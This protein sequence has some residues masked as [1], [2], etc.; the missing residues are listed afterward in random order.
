MAQKFK[1]GD[2]VYCQHQK[3]KGFITYVDESLDLIK[4]AF[5][6]NTIGRAYD[7]TGHLWLSSKT[8]KVVLKKAKTFT[9]KQM[10]EF[11]NWCIENGVYKANIDA[12][13]LVVFINQNNQENQ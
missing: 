4:V 12:K 1:V 6:N 2:L 8:N 9:P 5:E 11:A 10:I 7:T 3:K 13:D